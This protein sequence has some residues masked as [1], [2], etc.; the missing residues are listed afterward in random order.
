MPPDPQVDA[1]L[2][3]HAV[4]PKFALNTSL[5]AVSACLSQCVATL[6]SLP[7]CLSERLGSACMRLVCCAK[8][9]SARAYSLSLLAARWP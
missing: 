8:N 7:A 4:I 1:N 2:G 6:C 3:V 9:S 5:P